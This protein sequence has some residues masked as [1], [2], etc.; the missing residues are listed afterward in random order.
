MKLAVLLPALLLSVTALAAPPKTRLLDFSTETLISDE[1]AKAIL[2][3][4]IPAKVWKIY[5]ANKWV[6]LSQVEGGITPAGVCVITARVMLLPLTPTM[7]AVLLRP[8]KIA[9]SFDAQAGASR[10]ACQALAKTKLV[11]ATNA[12]V[13]ALVKV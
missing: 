10:E 13:S 7:K 6:F 1:A 8:E 11:E 4:H 5:P 9:T 3:E 2:T 12:V